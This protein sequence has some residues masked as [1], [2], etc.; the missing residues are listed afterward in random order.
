MLLQTLCLFLCLLPAISGASPVDFGRREFL[1][2]LESRGLKPERFKVITEHSM[3]LPSDGYSI[4]GYL[5]R[6]GNLRGIMYGLLEAAAQI[7]RSGRLRPVKAA[8]VTAIRGVRWEQPLPPDSASLFAN[9]ARA[10]VNRFIAAHPGETMETLRRA[11]ELATTHGLDFGA[12]LPAGASPKAYIAALPLLKFL[13]AAPT[14]ENLE[15]LSGAGRLFTLDL[16]ASTL[17]ETAFAQATESRIPLQVCAEPSAQGTFFRKP[18]VSDRT[19]PWQV[20]WRL[21]PAPAVGPKAVRALLAAIPAGGTQGFE[22][23]APRVPAARFY[24]IWGRLAYDPSTADSELGLG[25]KPTSS[26]LDALEA[27]TLLP[28]DAPLI[29]IEKLLVTPES[30]PWTASPAESARLRFDP[31][32]SAKSHPI[33]RATGYDS[34]AALLERAVAIEPALK[35]IV[36]HAR[37]AARRLFAAA[38]LAWARASGDLA[39]LANARQEAAEALK[40]GPGNRVLEEDAALLASHPPLPPPPEKLP[41]RLSGTVARPAF[42]HTAQRQASAG[43][44]LPVNLTISSKENVQLV[45]LYWRPLNRGPWQIIEAAPSRP[46]FSIPGGVI[47]AAFDVEYFFEILHDRGGGWFYPENPAGVFPSRFV[48]PVN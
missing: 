35:P 37:I 4:Q 31:R 7:R 33:E 48:V 34:A 26:L 22:L 9:L 23:V 14:K 29:P 18:E 41:G 39:A 15:E 40:L 16:D 38:H 5:I 20:I 12:V 19:R 43:Q 36:L 8:P 3:V 30:D 47:T 42:Q 17:S 27:A 46:S 13:E 32:S 21:R 25:S 6:G 44:P 2:A 10:R 24:E 45:R 11:S 1:E 28:P